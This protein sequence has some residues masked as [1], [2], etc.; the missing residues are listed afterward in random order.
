MKH[1]RKIL[2][3]VL[4]LGLICIILGVKQLGS[5]HDFL[6]KSATTSQ[7]KKSAPKVVEPSQEIVQLAD[8]IGLTAKG[9]ELFYVS[10]PEILNAEQFNEK[11]P[12]QPDSRAILGRYR[13]GKIFLYHIQN[14]ELEGIVE[15]TSAHEILHA[16]WVQLSARERKKVSKLLEENYQLLKTE[17]SE[18]LMADY[19][20]SEPGQREN[21]LHSILG[22]TCHN[23]SPNLEKY[24]AKYF[25]NREK[26]VAMFDNYQ[27]KFD[28]LEEKSK[29]LL[30]EITALK[31][32][33]EAEK[34]QYDTDLEAMNLEI[35]TFNSR[36]DNYYYTNDTD[37][38]ADR[39]LIEQK[40]AELGKRKDDINA[41]IADFEAKKVTLQ[42]IALKADDLNKSI[43][44]RLE[45][46]ATLT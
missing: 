11:V 8:K 23:L 30:S 16:A 17:K 43:D 22:T 34:A 32:V 21:E 40:V 25:K 28:E 36:A 19:E 7:S 38:Y 29:T 20:K 3:T 31:A 42:E 14:P 10:E 1:K 5:S 4:I 6:S 45:A 41:K 39:N 37:F 26:I 9:R 27:G 44:A 13:N 2:L 46:P 15:V 35:T 33:I 24:Y 18:A 12:N